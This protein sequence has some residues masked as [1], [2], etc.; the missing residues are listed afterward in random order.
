M[1]VFALEKDILFPPVS[2]A[3]ENGILAVGGDLSVERLLEAYKNGIF[4]WFSEKDPIIWWSPNPR[5]VLYPDEI[6]ISKSMRQVLNR[7]VFDIT[8]DKAFDEVIDACSKIERPLQD[9]TWITDE[10]ISSYKELHKLG[11]AHSVETWQNGNLVGGLYGLSMGKM[12]FGESMFAKVSNASKAAFVE[13]TKKLQ[14]KAFTLIDCQVYTKHLESLGA[15]TLSRDE[16]VTALH[17]N[18]EKPTILGSW[19]EL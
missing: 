14:K 16:F 11:Y 17:E 3:D 19:H 5:F 12:F 13:L 8:Y 18:L 7:K 6:K 2:L 1:T 15:K 4:P 9:G 10:M